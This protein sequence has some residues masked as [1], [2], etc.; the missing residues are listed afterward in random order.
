MSDVPRPWPQIEAMPAP[1]LTTPVAIGLIGFLTLVDLFAAQA[2][3]PSLAK[4]YG[5]SAAEI[6]LAANA[7]TLGMAMAGLLAGGPGARLERRRAIWMS[8]ALLAIPTALLAL[9]PNLA[10]FAILRVVQ[11]LFMAGAFTLTLA[12]LAERC[13]MAAAPGA[14]AAYVTGGVAS[15]LVGRLTAA[16]VASLVGPEASFLFF[17]LLNLAGAA[18]VAASLNRNPPVRG[19]G[20]MQSHFWSAWAA[21]LAEPRLRR[22]FAIGFLILFGFIGT[23]TYVGFVL[24]APPLSLSMRALGLVFLVFAPS[25]VTTPLAGKVARRHGAGRTLAASLALALAGLVLMLATSLAA[26]L[27]GMVLVGV[28]TFFAQAAATGYVGRTATRERTAASGL[29]LSAYYCGGLAGAA[30]VGQLFVRFGWNAAVAGIFA[31][32]ATAALLGL[33]LEERAA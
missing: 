7:G 17:A 2:I 10:V 15:N 9:A 8:L 6:G 23:F 12:Y 21:H 27:T 28:G 19:A 32:L 24:M 14:L 5:V 16:F 4:H 31:A 30:V 20:G 3:L 25:M 26:I 13:S 29:Y 11:G 22:A 33:R 1:R 18:L